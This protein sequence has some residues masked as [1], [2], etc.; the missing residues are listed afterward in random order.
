MSKRSR[1]KGARG[2]RAVVRAL[3]AIGIPA[4]RTA[5]LQSGYGAQ[6]GDVEAEIFGWKR[7]IEVK[8]RAKGFRQIYG[9]LENADVLIVKA[10]GKPA[11]VILPMDQAKDYL[12]VKDDG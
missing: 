3:Q 4:R 9:W 6:D 1:D 7:R 5:P 8:L 11:L 10:D 12:G 2:E